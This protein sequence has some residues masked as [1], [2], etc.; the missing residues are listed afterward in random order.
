MNTKACK[1]KIYHKLEENEARD[2]IL[3]EILIRNKYNL[4]DIFKFLSLLQ[5]QNR[6]VLN[7][8]Y[9]LIL[10]QEWVEVVKKAKRISTLSILSK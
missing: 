10:K 5:C 3:E 9:E 2:R 4:E 1:D 6:S 7:K 8:E